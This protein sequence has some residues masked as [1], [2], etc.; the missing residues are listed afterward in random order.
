[1]NRVLK[2]LSVALLLAGTPAFMAVGTLPVQAQAADPA[3]DQVQGFYDG[4]GIY[5]VRFMPGI[6][7][8]WS[9]LT[10]SSAPELGAPSTPAIPGIG[11]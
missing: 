4:D 6:Q 8:H 7:G 9:Y 2:S 10:S 1:M 3:V 11:N 5:R